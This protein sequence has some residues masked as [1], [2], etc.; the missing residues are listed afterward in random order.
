MELL[1][2]LTIVLAILQALDYYT[3]T[4]ILGRGGVELNPIMKGLMDKLGVKPT[5]IVK[6]I[7]V[8]AAG[9]FLGEQ[10]IAG[11]IAMVVVYIGII[12]FN[13]KSMPK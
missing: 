13:W 10:Q 11:L 3:T 12:A 1:I 6:G 7:I 9:Y 8:T 4:T 5:L 2:G